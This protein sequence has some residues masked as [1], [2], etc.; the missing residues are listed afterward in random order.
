MSSP[1][2]EY[3]YNAPI[4]NSISVKK[5][6]L[7]YIVNISTHRQLHYSLYQLVQEPT[8]FNFK[9]SLDLHRLYITRNR[10]RLIDA[11]DNINASLSIFFDVTY[12]PINAEPD[13]SHI[14]AKAMVV[15][16][17]GEFREVQLGE[18]RGWIKVK[19]IFCTNIDTVITTELADDLFSEQKAQ[20]VRA[21]GTILNPEVDSA[22]TN[23]MNRQFLYTVLQA[24]PVNAFSY[25][26]TPHLEP[27][28]TPRTIA[29]DQTTETNSSTEPKEILDI[30][31]STKKSSIDHW[32]KLEK[33]ALMK[34]ARIVSKQKY[35]D[36]MT[37]RVDAEGYFKQVFFTQH[38]DV[39][40]IFQ[41]STASQRV[42]EI[43]S[44]LKMKNKSYIGC[45]QEIIMD[46]RSMEVI[47]LTMDRYDMTLRDYL[48]AHTYQRLT[49]YQRFDIIVQMIQ[50]IHEI[51]QAGI[52]HRDLS[53]VN[54]MVNLQ[55]EDHDRL[56]DGSSKV[57]LYLIDFGKA[58]L[59]SP[60]EAQRWWVNTNECYVYQDEVKPTTPEELTIWCKNLP[61]VMARPDH[62][63]RFYR[64]IQT[65]P[66][67][68]RDHLLLDHMIDPIAED[69]YSLGT[70]VWKMFSGKEP[71][72]GIFDTD[73]KI[74]RDSVSS[75]ERIDIILEREIPGP[76]SKQ[77]LRLFLRAEPWKR[78]TTADILAWLDQPTV[79][80]SLLNEWDFSLGSR[81]V[82]PAASR[83]GS[84][85]FIMFPIKKQTR[86]RTK[87]PATEENITNVVEGN[88]SKPKTAMHQNT[89]IAA[90]TESLKRTKSEIDNSSSSLIMQTA[91][92]YKR[93]KHENEQE[94]LTFVP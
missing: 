68:Q 72:P 74:L 66:R 69:V 8:A 86:K 91:M 28:Y 70:L 63:Y 11:R 67:S 53:T 60:E 82:T 20:S 13:M 73:I 56:P 7:M 18:I 41:K 24:S 21:L 52:A 44:L 26:T 51:H 38:D 54:F 12:T 15:H 64:S 25:H 40:Q 39:V 59:L 35:T 57:D 6:S 83:K 79:M 46:D 78:R 58:I 36:I 50:S 17:L 62:G 43:V 65:L 5:E 55:K 89:H 87:R 84:P 75:D 80:Q 34:Q 45:I 27:S 31:T 47:G 48:N 2:I 29:L 61:Y 33:F 1:M 9:N 81:N 3:N 71:W 42:T 92:P 93:L 4:F 37:H 22:L 77:F 88:E 23:E 10:K 94:T 49:H 30:K 16:P 90:C 76:M 32:K 14:T 85:D 19:V